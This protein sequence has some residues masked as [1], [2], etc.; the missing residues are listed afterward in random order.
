MLDLNDIKELA[1]ELRSATSAS[2][3]HQGAL[4]QLVDVCRS[5]LDQLNETVQSATMGED[6]ENEYD[7]A[8]LLTVHEMVTDSIEAAEKKR[9]DME[10]NSNSSHDRRDIY[11]LLCHLRGQKQKRYDAVWGLLR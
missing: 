6:S 9:T 11:S 5:N 2:D 7:L 10:S 1:R 8:E 3:A 4:S